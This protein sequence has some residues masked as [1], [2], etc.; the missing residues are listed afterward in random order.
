[1]GQRQQEGKQKAK[2][3]RRLHEAQQKRRPNST[4]SRD[5]VI[6]SHQSNRLPNTTAPFPKNNQIKIAFSFP[7]FIQHFITKQPQLYS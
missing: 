7:S 3:K 4:A 5:V 1:M 6:P 2:G